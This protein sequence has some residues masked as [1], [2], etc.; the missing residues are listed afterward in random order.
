MEQKLLLFSTFYFFFFRCC[1]INS[2]WTVSVSCSFFNGSCIS[3]MAPKIWFIDWKFD[4]IWIR[5][6]SSCLISKIKLSIMFSDLSLNYLII[7]IL[8][9]HLQSKQKS[10]RQAHTNWRIINLYNFIINAICELKKKKM[11]FLIHL[12]NFALGC[13]AQFHFSK[14]I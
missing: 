6:K 2:Y 1:H 3:L 8:L 5:A 12:N 14:C 10:I 13:Y 4:I 9:N 7:I 11:L